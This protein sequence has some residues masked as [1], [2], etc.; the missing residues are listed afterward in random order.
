LCPLRRASGASHPPNQA[1]VIP[2][3]SEAE[4]VWRTFRIVAGVALIVLGLLGMVLPVLPGIPFLLAGG[5]LLG[6]NHPWV[7]P[8]MVR[9]RLWRR[10][11]ARAA[12]TRQPVGSDHRDGKVPG[13]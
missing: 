11:R 10:K 6:T 1:K 2:S 3:A 4:I 12:G 8:F 5:A 7:R 9:F 13:R